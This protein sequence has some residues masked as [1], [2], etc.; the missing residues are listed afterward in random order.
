MQNETKHQYSGSDPDSILF[1]NLEVV[2]KRGEQATRPSSSSFAFDHIVSSCLD[3]KSHLI[4]ATVEP[5]LSQQEEALSLTLCE[6]ALF[7]WS[8]LLV[9]VDGDSRK[10]KAASRVDNII[11]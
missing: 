10:R 6:L 9:G 11:M 1:F 7:A 8:T 3:H 5:C 4:L 2:V